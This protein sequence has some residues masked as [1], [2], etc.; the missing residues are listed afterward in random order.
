VLDRLT[1]ESFLP[2]VGRPFVAR[3][4]EERLELELIAA[5]A[6]GAQVPDRL[7][8][9][10]RL[11]F[12][13]PAEPVLAQQIQRLENEALGVLEIFLVPVGRDAAATTY[14]AIFA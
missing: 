4:G 9:P 14:E 8:A 10:F 6:L 5:Q 11:E 1:V 12:R 7:R 2:E 13:G 3:G